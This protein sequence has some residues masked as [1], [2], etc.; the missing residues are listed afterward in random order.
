MLE[1]Y[2]RASLENLPDGTI[3]EW[4]RVEDDRTS[5]AVAFVNVEIDYETPTPHGGPTRVVWISPGGWAPMTVDL[6]GIN[7]P[8]KVVQLG[9]FRADH[10]VPDMH[11]GGVL[12]IPSSPDRRVALEC[13]ARVWEGQ[14]GRDRAKNVIDTAEQFLAWLGGDEETKP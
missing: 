14:G 2:D 7:Y 13:A 5:R 4:L 9:P 6:A 12:P 3:I 11:D 8:V 1:I 10:M